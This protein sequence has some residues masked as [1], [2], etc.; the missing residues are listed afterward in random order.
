MNDLTTVEIAK[1]RLQVSF[2]ECTPCARH[3]LGNLPTLI[4]HSFIRLFESGTWIIR[5][6]LQMRYLNSGISGSNFF[7]Y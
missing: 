2:L 6:I 1:Q 7:I 3:V 5:S 4:H